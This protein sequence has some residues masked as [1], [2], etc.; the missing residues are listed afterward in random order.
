M[1]GC[2][3]EKLKNS[4]TVEYGHDGKNLYETYG[5]LALNIVKGDLEKV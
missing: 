1:I 3:S 5:S 4:L 2:S